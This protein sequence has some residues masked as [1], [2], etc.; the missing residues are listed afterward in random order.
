[1]ESRVER[2]TVY[3]NGARV[4]RVTAAG[5][6]PGAGDPPARVRLV[7]LPLAVIDGTARVE[8]TG[9]A[10]ATS[11]RVG[12][13]AE[14]TGA[15]EAPEAIAAAR[16]RAAIARAEV[17]R[18]ARAIEQLAGAPVV[19]AEPGAPGAAPREPAAPWGEVQAARRALVAL[20]AE[21]GAALRAQ[22][23][24]AREAAAEAERALAAAEDREQR[25]SL[26]RPARAHELR[27]YAEV[28]LAAVGGEPSTAPVVIALE[29]LV[30]AARWAPSY[31]ARI[32]GQTVTLELRAS[33]AQ[34]TGEDWMG[35]PLVLATAEPARFAPLPELAPQRI[36]RRQRAPARR[37][38]RPAPAG[39]EALYAD[40]DRARPRPRRAAAP[41]PPAAAVRAQG[42]LAVDPGEDVLEAAEAQPA[43]AYDSA[44]PLRAAPAPR[45]SEPER[46]MAMLERAVT[47]A[48]ADEDL[49]LEVERSAPARMG[50]GSRSRAA[51]PA[52]GSPERAPSAH[53]EP[54]PRAARLD[55]GELVM[56][57]PGAP[58]RGRL[59][60]AASDDRAAAAV[61]AELS[62]ARAR[63]AAL[64]LPPACA[65][66]PAHAHAY[67]Y[68]FATDGAVDVPST[69]AWLSIA[70]MARSAAAALRHIAVPREQPAAFRVAE[71]TNPLPGPLLPGPI[72]IYERGQYLVE[73]RVAGAPPG[74]A[75]VLGLGVDPRVKI[76]RNAE[77]SEEVSGV[78][79]G[80]LR[81]VHAVVVDIANH[82][83]RSIDLEVRERVP[84]IR[85]GAS[86]VEVTLGRVEPPWERWTPDP[87]AP[88]GRRLRGGYRWRVT[89]PAHQQRQLRAAYEVKLSGKLE[90]V[91]GNRR[92]P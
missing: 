33:V 84:V 87:E 70:V 6:W 83:G 35:V 64:A 26:A 48:R 30:A 12:V 92:E 28:E 20:H 69:G 17:E 42:A 27:K 14:A 22:L 2:V 74:G 54:A 37:G 46:K 10:R 57:G 49:D 86:D 21:R 91:G 13:T 40:Y 88:R 89:V 77:L 52:P 16:L 85:E 81:L 34:E 75:V 66:E 29:Y 7:G 15:P 71:L 39:A 23:T 76:A 5:A 55:Y 18:V 72:D 50:A 47:L 90:L 61:A 53:A 43:D 60:A 38:F 67:D 79:R 44:A 1:M 62:A 63:V 65:P 11:V 73:S 4:R 68:A 36:G 82:S 9:P 24:A 51:R 58:A 41:E 45:A 80:A 25:A 59:T 31:V 32:D 56:P 8:V 3:G 78:L 19:A